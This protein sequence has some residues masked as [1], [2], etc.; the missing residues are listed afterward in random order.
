MREYVDIQPPGMVQFLACKMAE[1]D[2][3]SMAEA[4][5]RIM[6]AIW[7]THE[8]SR[9]MLHDQRAEPEILL[10]RCLATKQQLPSPSHIGAWATILCEV[11]DART[12]ID[13]EWLAWVRSRTD[14][15][16]SYD[17]E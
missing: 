9:L 1:Q 3:T 14:R 10:Q 5:L 6:F 8:K 4:M 13:R 2:G 17:N 16:T 12:F 7:W 15:E 11:P